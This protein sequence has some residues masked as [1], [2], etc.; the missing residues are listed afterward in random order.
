MVLAESNPRLRGE[1]ARFLRAADLHVHE[2][3][4]LPET[5]D[6][7]KRHK[8]E[9]ICYDIDLPG[10]DV[11]QLIKTLPSVGQPL[12][13]VVLT[14]KPTADRRRLQAAAQAGVRTIVV[15]PCRIELLLQRISLTVNM[16]AARGNRPATVNDVF[17]MTRVEGNSS[18]LQQGM[19]CPFHESRKHINRFVLRAGKMESEPDF[20]DVPIYTKPARGADYVNYNQLAV[21]VCPECGFAT[22]NPDY[23][24]APGD[25]KQKPPQF[26]SATRAAIAAGADQRRK[27]IE[28]MDASFLTHNRSARD[29]VTTYELAI[30][31]AQAMHNASPHTFTPELLRLGN[32][33]L[34]IASL[35]KLLGAPPEEAAADIRAA[36]ET[37]K[38]SYTVTQ[39][40]GLMKNT[41][42]LIAAAIYFGDDRAANQYLMRLR[43][44]AK[45]TTGPD[46]NVA[47]RYLN[48]S[49]KA[50]EDRDMHRMPTDSNSVILDASAPFVQAA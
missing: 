28:S 44:M 23:F 46:Q 13:G 47:Q 25:R 48:R 11:L 42:Q 15:V 34:R 33:H 40:P 45:T 24:I 32:Y 5:L 38:Q 43:E 8:P 16:L 22:L 36:Y 26:D 10:G 3:A 50:W 9:V 30:S 17:A 14:C 1:T 21:T 39:G 31:C 18:L 7:I 4:T 12:P 29:A 27:I 35:R 20:F 37:L 19:L 49:Q 2:A 6:L 41:Y